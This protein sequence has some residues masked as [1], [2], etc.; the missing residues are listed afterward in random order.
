MIYYIPRIKIIKKKIILDL[1]KEFN[2]TSYMEVP[3]LIKIVLSKGVGSAVLDKK[4][5]H[6]AMEELTLISGQKSIICFSKRDESG[7]KLRKGFPIGVKVTL[8]RDRM[9]EFFYRLVYVGLPRVR[10]FNGLNKKKGFDGYGN[11]N[12]GIKENIIFPEIDIDNLKT[13]YGMDI[14][15]VTSAKTDKEALSL[16]IKLGLPFNKK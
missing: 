8:R 15:F 3:K 16:L 10:D 13:N 9:Y 12:I 4:H 1:M 7:F 14:T 2:Y 11:Y 5:I 6:Y